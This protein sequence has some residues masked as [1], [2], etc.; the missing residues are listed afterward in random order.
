[1]ITTGGLSPHHLGRL[2]WSAELTNWNIVFHRAV[3][4][5][6]V[7][8]H[9]VDVGGLLLLGD[10]NHLMVDVGVIDVG[11]SPWERMLLGR[12]FVRCESIIEALEMLQATEAL[13]VLEALKTLHVNLGGELFKRLFNMC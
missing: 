4:V 6:D 1:M 7:G 3:R 9:H 8:T 2:L 10:S 5:H 13:K 11:H 12:G